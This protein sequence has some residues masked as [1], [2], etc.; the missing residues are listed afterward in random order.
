MKKIISLYNKLQSRLKNYSSKII[1]DNNEITLKCDLCCLKNILLVL[2]TDSEFSFNQ[3]IDLCGV[4]YLDYGKSDWN[5]RSATVYGF[6]RAV[7]EKDSQ[8]L[9]FDKNR[10]MVVYHLLSTEKNYRVRIK[11]FVNNED[12]IVPSVCDIWEVA[13]WFER[14]TYDMYGIL[15]D[16]HPDLRRI[17]TDYGFMHYPLRKDFPI[18]GYSEIRYDDNLG[19]VVYE[20]VNIESR[21]TVPKVVK[22]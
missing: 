16:G 11:S 7:L 15:F 22:L 8:M 2:K 5:V 4:D 21:I 6:S 9:N 12:L 17:L 18:I 19:K 13:D 3:L 10:F 20:P 1:I 14:E